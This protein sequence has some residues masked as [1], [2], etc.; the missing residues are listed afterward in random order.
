MNSNLGNQEQGQSAA[1][2]Q[3]IEDQ[4]TGHA[5]EPEVIVTDK[6]RVTS[7][8]EV[9]PVDLEPD[10]QE[11]SA[12]EQAEAFSEVEILQA[13]L[14]ETEEKRIEAE[15]QSRDFSD[16]FRHAQAKLRAETDEQRARLQRTFDQKLEAAR[17]DVLAGLLDTLDNLKRAVAAAEKNENKNS[18][19]VA[20]LD[21]VRATAQMFEARMQGL[22][23]SAVPAMGEEFN[24]E[25]HEAVEIVPVAK[26]KDNQV[27]EEFQTGYRFGDRLLRPAR[28]RVGRANE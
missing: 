12:S 13:K 19:F 14:R 6:R 9:I 1:E 25:V 8:G 2:A 17:G 27:I 20:L 23:L 18:D 21:G 11:D 10:S 28:V 16:R 22:G 24:P 4:P 26:D 15:R 5:T 7:E 3:E